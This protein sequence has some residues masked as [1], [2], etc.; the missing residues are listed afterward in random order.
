MQAL[1]KDPIVQQAKCVH[2]HHI[3]MNEVFNIVTSTV[4]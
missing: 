4:C 2:S 3:I 1:L